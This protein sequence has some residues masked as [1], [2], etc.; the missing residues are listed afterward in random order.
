M[1][2]KVIVF[3]DGGVADVAYASHGVEV[4]IVDFDNLREE[5]KAEEVMRSVSQEIETRRN[6]D[7]ANAT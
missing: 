2:E 6:K 3:V 5:G 4:E 1:K 7:R